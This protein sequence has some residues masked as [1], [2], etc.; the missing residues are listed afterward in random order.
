MDWL[1][2]VKAGTGYYYVCEGRSRPVAL[3]LSLG[4]LF[5]AWWLCFLCA[6]FGHKWGVAHADAENGTEEIYCERCGYSHRCQF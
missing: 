5:T 6:R 4:D 1:E 2:A 3:W